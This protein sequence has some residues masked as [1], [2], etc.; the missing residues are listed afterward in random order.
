MTDVTWENMI[1]KLRLVVP[2]LEERHRRELA[3]WG[4]EEPG[5]HPFYHVVLNEYLTGLLDA[6]NNESILQRIFEFIEELATHTDQRIREVVTDTIL[7]R[8]VDKKEWIVA[9]RPYM[10]P[11]TLQMSGEVERFWVDVDARYGS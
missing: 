8:L 1:E 10:G 7:E 6:G 4:E 11:E 9:A 2:E 5:R 3:W